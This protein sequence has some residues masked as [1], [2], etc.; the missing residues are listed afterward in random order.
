MQYSEVHRAGA[1]QRARRLT[2]SAT[3]ALMAERSVPAMVLAV[4]IPGLHEGIL[5]TIFV[6]TWV[7]LSLF[8]QPAGGFKLT[9]I[10][11]IIL[12]ILAFAVN[13]IAEWLT[14]RKIGSLLAGMI[15]TIL[16]TFLILAFVRLPAP[17]DF[18]IEDVAIIAALI[19]SIIIGVFYVL[20]RT[21]SSRTRA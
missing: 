20:L 13:A 17:L 19:G 10:D 12:A 7:S 18:A 15:V 2:R 11:L 8:G 1:L 3:V 5:K 14:G 9:L 16:G 4:A 6:D 21:R